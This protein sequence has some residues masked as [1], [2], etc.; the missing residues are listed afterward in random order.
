[1]PTHTKNK[2]QEE[3]N[4][5]YASKQSWLE[6]AEVGSK[7]VL[8]RRAKREDENEQQKKMKEELHMF[9]K[10]ELNKLRGEIYERPD[11]SADGDDEV[12]PLPKSR[13]V[14]PVILK[15]K[16]VGMFDAMLDEIERIEQ[17]YG[18][19]IPVVHG[20]IGNICQNDVVHAEVE[21]NYGYCPVYGVQVGVNPAAKS[22]AEKPCPP[23]CKRKIRGGVK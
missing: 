10:S 19:S 12:E 15:T 21:R 20:G 1:M 2:E 4:V 6:D 8:N 7:R 22:M 9:E 14:L 18:L 5:Y 3:D 13:P 16:S 17:R 11:I 23:V